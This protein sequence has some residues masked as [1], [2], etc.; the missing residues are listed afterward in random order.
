[1][2]NNKIYF[3]I[4]DQNG[5]ISISSEV[6]AGIAAD[7]CM[8]TKGVSSMAG[9]TKGSRGVAVSAEEERCQIEAYIM[10]TGDCVIADTAKAVQKNIKAKV[11]AASGISVD[12]CDVFVA[13]IE[14]KK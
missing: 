10:V 14:F 2:E 3:N 4:S 12:K 7:A 6:I 9:T 8:E 1:M 11:E 5:V 13:G